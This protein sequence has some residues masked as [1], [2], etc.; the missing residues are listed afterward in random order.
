MVNRRFR[1][2]I[3]ATFSAAALA[4]IP[5][6]LHAQNNQTGTIR[7]GVTDESGGAMPG[8]TVTLTSPALL[9]AQ[10]AV[11]DSTGNYHFEQ[12]PVGTYKVTFDLS[13]FRQYVRENVQITAGFSADI[14]VQMLVG[15]LEET[16]TVSSASPVVDTTST[17]VS[18]SVGAEMIAKHASVMFFVN[19]TAET[20]RWL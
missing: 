9:V 17:T 10:V 15:T 18:T 20:G 4:A 6:P 19:M 11:S 3:V 16:V 8:V 14:R 7:G 2:V 5:R 13:G 1:V 12:L